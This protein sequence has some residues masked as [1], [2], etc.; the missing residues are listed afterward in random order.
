MSSPIVPSPR[1]APMR[2]FAVLVAQVGGEAVDLGLDIELDL[3]LVLAA[4]EAADAADEVGHVLA[5]E[6]VVEREHR[7][8]VLDLGEAGSRLGADARARRIG[9]LQAGEQRLDRAV[10]LDQRVILRVA[11]LRRVLLVI[12]RV[13][14]GDFL[15][16]P[17]QL[18]LGLAWTELFGR[19]VCFLGHR[20]I[21]VVMFPPSNRGRVREGEAASPL[22]GT[23][24]RFPHPNPPPRL[25][26]GVIVAVCF[27]SLLPAACRRRRGLRR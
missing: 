24:A 27:I 6:G 4:Q 9:A 16:E 19:L 13:V 22:E 12:E 10:A 26:E 17:L 1:V 25:G 21:I 3:R 8:Q 7:V 23:F 15:G 5:V 20:S 2:E 11:D 14:V 18:G